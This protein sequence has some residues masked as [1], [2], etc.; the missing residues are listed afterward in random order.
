MYVQL[1]RMLEVQKEELGVRLDQ[2]VPIQVQ[3]ILEVGVRI[4]GQIVVDRVAAIVIKERKM[5]QTAVVPVKVH[6]L[7]QVHHIVDNKVVVAQISEQIQ[8][9][10]AKM[11]IQ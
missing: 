5:V 4:M 3:I 2:E 6:T 8:V 7:V 10:L 1:L 11:L 9:H